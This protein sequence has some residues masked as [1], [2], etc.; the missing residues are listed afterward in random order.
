VKV[1]TLGPETTLVL[2]SMVTGVLST[3]AR[4]NERCLSLVGPQ[5]DL[6]KGWAKEI[7]V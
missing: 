1:T 7:R 4:F 2:T 3:L 5:V 6:L